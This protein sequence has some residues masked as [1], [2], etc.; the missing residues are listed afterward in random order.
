MTDKTKTVLLVEDSRFLREASK[1]MLAKAGYQVLTAG[2]GEE[3]IRIASESLPDLIL[4]D[5]I[6]PK[7]QG[8][9]VL[10]QLK[11]LPTTQG[12]PVIMLSSNDKEDNVALALAAG[13]AGFIP[14]SAFSL[15]DMVKELQKVLEQILAK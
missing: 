8:I 14:K 7:T 15:T 9:D 13:A 2:D 6:M 12:I 11:S 1:S 10:K 5:W 3:A 4:L